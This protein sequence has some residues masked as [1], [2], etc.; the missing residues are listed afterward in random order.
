MKAKRKANRPAPK[1]EDR[2]GVAG[3]ASAVKPAAGPDPKSGAKPR[4]RATKA[5]LGSAEATARTKKPQTRAHKLPFQRSKALPGL[6][7]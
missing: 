4:S 7:D 3:K 6:P 1:T 5:S 2:K